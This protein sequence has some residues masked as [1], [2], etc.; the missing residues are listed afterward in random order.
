MLIFILIIAGLLIIDQITK[1]I[2]MN[3]MTLGQSITVI[4]DF[5]YFTSVRNT[6]AAWSKF[7]NQ[8]GFFYVITIIALAVFIYM[9]YKDGNLATKKWYT[10]SLLMIIAGAIGNFI[11]RLL[12]K[13]V[14]DFLDFTIFNYHYP[15]FN[16]ADIF[17]SVGTVIF[18]ISVLL[19]NE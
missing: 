9:L 6:G 13:E 2:V 12:Y 14:V 4:P 16:F 10:I 3:Q 7:E 15:V 5:F 17:L 19:M 1:M 18:A 8:M 11:D